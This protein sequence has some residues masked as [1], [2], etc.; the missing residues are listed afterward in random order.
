[1]FL[2]Y[3]PYCE[4]HREEEEFHPKGQAHI[5][6]PA[7]PEACSDE[8]WGDYL[9]FRD[10]PRGIHHELWVHAVGCR[11]FFNITRNTVTYEILETYRI[12]E[13]PRFTAEYPEGKPADKVAAEKVAAE[14]EAVSRQEGVKA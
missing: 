5:A 3:C 12:G 14:S 10:N 11:K 1:M 6:R 2:I 7:D 13:Q 9:F 4:E 8:Q